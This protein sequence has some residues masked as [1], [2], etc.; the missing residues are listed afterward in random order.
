MDVY[1]KFVSV[2]FIFELFKV[3][4][5]KLHHIQQQIDSMHIDL[6]I[7]VSATLIQNCKQSHKYLLP[8]FLINLA[9]IKF[10]QASI[11]INKSL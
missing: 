3:F 4:I 5:M 6:E 7:F 10:G 2:S 9:E 11:Q 8:F 1:S